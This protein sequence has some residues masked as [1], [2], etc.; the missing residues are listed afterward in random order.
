MA[1]PK[2]V[3]ATFTNNGRGPRTFFS[4]EGQVHLLPGQSWTGNVLEAERDALPDLVGAG[5]NDSSIHEYPSL[6]GLNREQ[7][8]S[9]AA[10]EGYTSMSADASAEDIRAAIEHA[11]ETNAG[12]KGDLDDLNGKSRAALLKIAEKEGV[13]VE[14]DDNR[15]QLALKI[16]EA[17][18][19][20]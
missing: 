6:D 4:T 18:A 2:T 12:M 8:L 9:V 14:T 17:R 7:L 10:D 15:D 13:A 1:D 3:E 5:D 20:K 16:A 11:R 19:A